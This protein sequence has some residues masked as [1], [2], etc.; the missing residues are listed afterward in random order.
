MPETLRL[1]ASNQ[2]HV[3]QVKT[4]LLAG[5]LVAIPTETVYGLAA[6]AADVEA[7]EGIYRAKGRPENHPLIVHIGDIAGLDEWA[8]DI[9]DTAF[10]LARQ[11]W[12]GPLTLI[13]KKNDGVNTTVTGGMETIA[14]RMPSQPVLLDILK[15]TGL[16]LAA[17]SANPYGQLSATSAVQVM[18]T[19]VGKIHAV[20]DAGQCEIGLESTIVDPTTTPVRILRSGP[21]TA[22]QL[23]NALG[24]PVVT[25]PEHNEA[26]S[27]NVKAHYQPRARLKLV[28]KPTLLECLP[29]IEK[30]IGALV[31]SPELAGFAS[32]RLIILAEDKSAYA[33]QLYYS[34][35]KLDQPGIDEIWLEKPPEEEEWMD[36]N[37]RLRRATYHS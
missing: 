6:N 32:E 36:V 16:A 14:L 23:Q 25:P 13:L 17:P 30:N 29:N 20:L 35:Y 33:K 28:D 7:V 26:V 19:M 37:D 9:P 3:C 10:Q 18:E 24:T 5:K 31:Y 4:L 22:T 11:F 8:K 34:I 2:G 27:G 12:P 21:I 15:D 1:D